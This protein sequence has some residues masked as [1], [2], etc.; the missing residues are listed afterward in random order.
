MSEMTKYKIGRD[1]ARKERAQVSVPSA[2]C[3]LS[4]NEAA[5][6]REKYGSNAI[7][8][9][10]SP[11][12]FSCFLSNLNDPIIKI[13]IAALV[14]NTIFSFSDYG[15]TESI[16]IALTVLISITVS[17]VSE[18]SSGKAF[19][20]LYSALGDVSC[21]VIRN[22]EEREIELSMIVRN[23]IAVI[24]AGDTAPADGILLRGTVTA[25]EAALTGESRGVKK[26][27]SPEA[28]REYRDSPDS[29]AANRYPSSAVY[30]GSHILSGEAVILVTA[31][32]D[33]TLYGSIAGEMAGE[34]SVSPLRERLTTL[35]RTIS[36]IG[37][38]SA[39]VIAAVHLI[40]AF[41]L[42]AGMSL[43]CA[44]SLL[45]DTKY[46]F[47][48]LI[49]ALTL[50]ISVVVVA[51][52]EGLPMMITIVLSSNMKRMLRSGVL[53]RRL[54]GIETAGS[55]DMLF[56]DKTGTLT[57]GKLS[58]QCVIDGDGNEYVSWTAVSGASRELFAGLKAAC[59]SCSSSGN[60][61]ER[62][63]CA[64][65][66]EK[67]RS[68]CI[69]EDKKLSFSSERKF[70]AAVSGGKMYIQ[71]AADYLLPLCTSYTAKDGRKC[72]I[73][74]DKYSALEEASARK[75]GASRR[76]LVSAEGSEKD[77]VHLR[78]GGLLS[79][80]ALTLNGIYVINDEI[81]NEV[82]PSIAECRDAGIQVVMI[83]GDS[84]ATAEKIAERCGIL[85]GAHEIYTPK[86]GG[87][88]SLVV[89][90][91]EL[92]VME[93]DELKRIL[94]RIR[95]LSRVT[96]TDKSRLVKLAR[97]CGHI[98]GMTGDGV[99]DAPALKNADVGFAM[100]SG[101]D[102]ARE[103][104]D[105][106]ITDDNFVSITKAVLFGRTI[107]KSIRKFIM[108][109]L[110]MNMAAVGVSVLGTVFGIDSPVTVIQMLW[111][112][113]IMDTL[114][115]LAFAGEP[116]LTDYMREKPTKKSE[117]ILTAS[118]VRRV[119][120]RGLF[121]LGVSMLFLLSPGMRCLFCGGGVCHLTGF[122]ALFVFMGIG[123]AFC[124]RTERL[125]ILHG[126]LKN[127]AFIL[128]MPAVA[129]IQLLIVYFG[130]EVFRC[131]PL[132]PHQLA[133]CAVMAFSVVP[134]D[135]VRKAAIRIISQQKREKHR[136]S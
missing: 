136:D 72:A 9:R 62:A 5:A 71:G 25:D 57:T 121:A 105:I 69:G 131:T 37:Y 12:F 59:A 88:T 102:V 106:V 10:K 50:A 1:E 40:D 109:Q 16:G 30:K 63:I 39:G 94:P 95:V 115:S 66:G 21:T 13:L 3:G 99:N 127:K 108:Y 97:E 93:D 51:V 43:S 14:I 132:D 53:V 111:V 98:V 65:L 6:S 27:F 120:L 91:A 92:H 77:F 7:T 104:G 124:T 15:W 34:N 49:K 75:T 89:D 70:A 76:L 123:I 42:E 133:I 125:N 23:D 32:G 107:F 74:Y 64:F 8:V 110:T 135:T 67:G 130:G 55:I 29:F 61:T 17:T 118:M 44:L 19:E 85:S 45:K 46:L 129:V 24:R 112:N 38:V 119:T 4:D 56:T 81:R 78:S 122:F 80:P 90:A 52:P 79:R 83:T 35:A 128:I 103:A 47:S 48:E 82:P 116:A 22:G 26:E 60:S 134:A 68:V 36:K 96:P 31:V 84:C 54:V 2:S 33:S 86:S 87:S 114:G 101:S 126:A 73:S 28:L 100:G 58:V 117:S 113:I 18:R 20:K 11:G 41:W